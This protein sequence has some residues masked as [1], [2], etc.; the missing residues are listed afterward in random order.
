MEA[1]NN[2]SFREYNFTVWFFRLLLFIVGSLITMVFVLKINETVTISEGQIVAANP[3]ADYKAPF[4]A[5]I[6]KV[7]V[8]E[9]QAVKA[10]DTLLTMRNPDNIE[11]YT[12]IKSEIEYVQKK[13]KSIDILQQAVQSKRA[14]V[15][16]TSA[17]TAKRYQLDINRLVNDMKTLDQQYGL[18]KERLSSAHEKYL[19][20]SIL[21]KKDMLSKYEYNNTKEASLALKENLTGTLSERNKR[22]AE[23]NMAYND[24]T[25]EQNSLML[26]KVQ[27]EENTQS[28][29]QAKN[30]Y[31][32]QLKQAQAELN[33]LSAEVNDQNIV[34]QTAGIVN[35]LFN[36]SKLTNVINKGELLV[37]L[38]PQA[39]SYYAK[40]IVPE[41]DMPYVRAGLNAQLKLDAYH[42]F[43]N[44]LIK[45][46]VTYVAERKEN[47]KFYALVELDETKRFQLKSG[48]T[49][50]GE[51]VVQRLPLYKYFIKRLFKRFDTSYT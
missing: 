27:L 31:E 15:E 5:Q 38:A 30:E 49:V 48:Y 26:S 23:K 51:I 18:Q 42:N 1:L 21:Y 3:Q 6:E 25:R 47:E 45:G 34:A 33:K 16:Q 39:L 44:G 11:Q 24:F 32:N 20:D 12:K 19:G 50:Y 22:L 10:G 4:D 2:Y 7:Y 35:F 13:I 36:T 28:L 46:R 37:S 8:K 41:K 17:I 14:A 43:E 40:V 29:I 9:G